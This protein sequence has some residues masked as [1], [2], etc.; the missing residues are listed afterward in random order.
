MRGKMR[1][2]WFGLCVLGLA[3]GLRAWGQLPEPGTQ[4]ATPN[5]LMDSTMS[6]GKMQLFDLDTRFAKDVAV[7]GWAAFADW[8]A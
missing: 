7:R 5:P 2:I 6:A 8:F 3:G 1:A 4:S